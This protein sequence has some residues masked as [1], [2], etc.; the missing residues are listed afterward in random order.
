MSKLIETATPDIQMVNLKKQ[1]LN[2]KEEIDTAIQQVIDSTQFIKGP[3]VKEFEDHLS[4]YLDVKEVI[5]CANGTDA[6]QV[7]LMA[8]GLQAG[9][10]VIVPAFTYVATAEVIALLGL[11]PVM[12]DVDPNDFNIC[13]ENIEKAITQSTKAI[14]PVHL[15]GQCCDLEEIMDLAKQHNL[16]VVEDNAQAIGS[17]YT[18][19][20]ERQQKAGTVGHIGTTS[21]FPSKNLGCYGDG[22]A[23]FTNDEVLAYKIRM[24]A[25][26]GQSKKYYH[27]LIGLNSRLDAIQAAILTVKLQY[28][29]E[30]I[31]ARQEVAAQYDAGFQLLDYLITPHRNITSS[32]VFHQ[33]TLKTKGINR[34]NFAAYLN[35]HNIPSAIY[36]PLPLYQ[37]EAFRPYNKQPIQLPITEQLCETV[38]SL[39]MHTEME[40]EDLAYIIHT[41]QNYTE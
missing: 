41:I 2:I 15:F 21:F 22:G 35:R 30:Y 26:H 3:K 8:L 20:D 1:Y 29:D 13:I 39:P 40:K 9:D 18:F 24:I 6:L 7:A 38:I 36:Y 19:K 16:Y 28:L 32:H 34:N 17:T 27:Q 23:I 37:Q 25:N 31:A 11:Q 5:G 4:N 10:E 33:Y 12:V 14:V